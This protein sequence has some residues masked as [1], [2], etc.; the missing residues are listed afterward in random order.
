MLIVDNFNVYNSYQNYY[1]NFTVQGNLTKEGRSYRYQV[2][3]HDGSR[4]SFLAVDA[5][6]KPGIRRPFNFIGRLDSEEL[7][8]VKQLKE[9]SRSSNYT[10][11]FGH[12]PTSSISNANDIKKIIR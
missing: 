1:K 7:E 10:I 9:Q 3:A 12:Y 11:W 5:C 4:Y 6:L 8:R 2:D